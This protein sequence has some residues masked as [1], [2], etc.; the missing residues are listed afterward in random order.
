MM[1][2]PLPRPRLHA[3]SHGF[4]HRT[5][6]T[7]IASHLPIHTFRN[8]ITLHTL[9]VI[10]SLYHVAFRP[11][12][13]I[14]LDA[15]SRGRASNSSAPPSM[16]YLHPRWNIA[17]PYKFHYVCSWIPLTR[18]GGM[19]SPCNFILESASSASQYYPYDLPILSGSDI[20]RARVNSGAWVAWEVSLSGSASEIQSH[21][22]TTT[23]APRKS[24]RS[25][26]RQRSP[27]AS[28]TA[29]PTTQASSLFDPGMKTRSATPGTSN[30]DDE[31]FASNRAAHGKNMRKRA[32]ESDAEEQVERPPAKK[33]GMPYVELATR[34]SAGKGKRKEPVSD[35][36]HASVLSAEYY[37]RLSP[38]A[39]SAKAKR[40]SNLLP[41]RTPKR[42]SCLT[43]LL[44]TTLRRLWKSRTTADPNFKEATRVRPRSAT[45]MW[46]PSRAP[47][48]VPRRRNPS[49]AR[50][51][52]LMNRTR[53]L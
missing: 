21:T 49:S 7:R 39:P 11:D 20:G 14:G 1:R 33:R 36:E 6:S 29:T 27:S 10:S 52:S 45:L 44:N 24:L 3:A 2:P 28:A 53:K 38:L 30:I 5:L 25:S 15:Y 41:R 18:V 51:T 40:W 42:S 46:N 50:T 31:E 43:I 12:T 48:V 34:K 4:R 22:T 32:A 16:I 9:L 37:Y 47:R 19:W 13:A 23:M 8:D 17:A 35:M 26:A